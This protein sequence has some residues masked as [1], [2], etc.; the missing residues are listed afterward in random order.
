MRQDI[1][2]KLKN[3]AQKIL[4]INQD[5]DNTLL[6][7]QIKNLHD[8]LIILQYIEAQ[9]NADK[10]RSNQKAPE[11]TVQDLQEFQTLDQSEKFVAEVGEVFQDKISFNEELDNNN[12]ATDQ[13]AIEEGV[14]EDTSEDNRE[15]FIP[16]FDLVKEDFSL[17]EEFKDAISL[18]DTEKLFETKKEDG[19]QLS[20]NDRLVQNSIQV[21]LND[22]IAFVN[23]L[24]NFSQSE[25]NKELTV[26]NKF[27]TEKEAKDYIL[28]TL[29]SKY[30]W[31]G[32]DDI[33][34]RFVGLVERK[35][36]R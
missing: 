19:K 28:I 5:T 30:K 9:D 3:T 33:I 34:E 10:L 24:F 12:D 18:D 7:E 16:T 4:E 14:A 36:L 35:F 21:G 32:K 27:L 29:K 13:T 22:R 20:L 23:N 31:Q 17:K 1:I 26:L 11:N 25:F 8:Q 2:D 15:I 6:I